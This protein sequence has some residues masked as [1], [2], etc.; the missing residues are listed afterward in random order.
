MIQ[1]LINPEGLAAANVV[2]TALNY[3]TILNQCAWC[4]NTFIH[5]VSTGLTV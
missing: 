1:E 2:V 5:Y 4:R 3:P